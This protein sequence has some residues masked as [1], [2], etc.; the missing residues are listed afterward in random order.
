MD[1]NEPLEKLAS[2]GLLKREPPARD[3]ILGLLRTATIRL[4]DAQR[5]INAPESRFDL[6]YNAA[7][8][9]GK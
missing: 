8:I 1:R 3:E 9:T 5:T 7:A 6:A 4:A 2:T